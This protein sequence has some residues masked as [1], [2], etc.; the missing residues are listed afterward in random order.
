MSRMLSVLL[1][2][3]S[4]TSLAQA[5]F[6]YLIPADDGKSAQLVFSDALAPDKSVPI[7]KVAA[8]KLT[9]RHNGK[10]S[11]VKT[12]TSGN[13]LSTSLLG[14]GLKTLFGH[15]D[16][17]VVQKGDA[18]PFHLHYHPKTI[19]GDVFAKE[20]T[21]GKEALIEIVAVREGK[22]VKFLVLTEGKPLADAEVFVRKPNSDKNETVKTDAKG[23][24][25]AFSDAG[26]YGV[27]AR[28]L[29]SKQGEQNGKKYEEIRHYATLVVDVP[30]TK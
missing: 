4:M 18:K 25:T 15:T 28:L 11:A 13:E 10:D 20:A 23:F 26:R 16:Y 5:H 29:V 24:T 7:A 14:D 3:C 30:V 6:V 19:I 17:G 21:I 22:N 8:T 12:E 1:L 9:L 2:V 27:V